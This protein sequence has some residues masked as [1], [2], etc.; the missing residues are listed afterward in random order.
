MTPPPCSRQKTK[1]NSFSICS[2]GANFRTEEESRGAPVEESQHPSLANIHG[3]CC[4][5]CNAWRAV[6]AGKGL[7]S[8]YSWRSR[9]AGPFMSLA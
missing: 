6:R 8:H 9:R 4:L 1:K 5:V 2:Y 7:T 3:I